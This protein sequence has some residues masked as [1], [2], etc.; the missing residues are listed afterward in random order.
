M[1]ISKEEFKCRICSCCSKGMDE[2]FCI[3][4][5]EEYYCSEECLHKKYSKKEYNSMF[6]N[7]IAYWTQ[8]DR[9]YEFEIYLEENQ[10]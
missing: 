7:D 9:D 3:N 4:D 5:G 2:G 8:W 10:I 6:K 1:V